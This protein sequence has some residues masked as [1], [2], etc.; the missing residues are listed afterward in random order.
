[1]PKKNPSDD[2]QKLTAEYNFYSILSFIGTSFN[3]D[4]TLIGTLSIS[5]TLLLV[6]LP[7]S[8]G[9]PKIVIRTLWAGRRKAQFTDCAI[10]TR[11][12]WVFEA[13]KWLRRNS[14]SLL[15]RKSWFA[16]IRSSIQGASMPRFQLF[17][18][19]NGQWGFKFESQVTSKLSKFL[20]ERYF[21]RRQQKFTAFFYTGCILSF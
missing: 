19:I 17:P 9:I 20:V 5:P 21:E 6:K 12:E 3:G 18:S 7:L 13:L 10:F 15:R 16:S 4:F 11:L 14:S 2:N 8:L 1:M